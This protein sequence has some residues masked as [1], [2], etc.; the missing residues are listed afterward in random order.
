MHIQ[1]GRSILALVRHNIVEVH[2]IYQCLTGR[3]TGMLE[4]AG[5]YGL[6]KKKTTAYFSYLGI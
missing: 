3:W 6:K 2:V 5:L 4:W 1:G